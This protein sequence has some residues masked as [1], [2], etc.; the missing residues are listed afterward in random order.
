MGPRSVY[1]VCSG[2]PSRILVH[3]VSFGPNL[4]VPKTFSLTADAR[5]VIVIKM[6]PKSASTSYRR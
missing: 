3:F 5:P 4:Y 1:D 2:F 6:L